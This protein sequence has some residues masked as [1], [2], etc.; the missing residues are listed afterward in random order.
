M[1]HTNPILKYFHDGQH[2][3]D[4]TPK[5]VMSLLR[6]TAGEIDTM[7]P[8]GPEKTAGLH[9]LLEA[10]DCFIRAALDG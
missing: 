1:N 2:L 6:Q 7:V 5:D 10:K 4:G 3:P 9:K 8:N